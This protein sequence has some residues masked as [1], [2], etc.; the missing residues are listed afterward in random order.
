[1]LVPSTNTS[2][3]RGNVG[4]GSGGDDKLIKEEQGEKRVWEEAVAKKEKE[5]LREKV[6]FSASFY[7]HTTYS[8]PCALAVL[9]SVG[10]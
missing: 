8:T 7:E 2:C 5:K 4:R 10:D 6:L 3:V 1:M 9:L